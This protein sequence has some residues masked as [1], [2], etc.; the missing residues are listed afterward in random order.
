M[1]F[2]VQQGGSQ[3]QTDDRRYGHLQTGLGKGQG[4]LWKFKDVDFAQPCKSLNANIEVE[5]DVTR[6]CVS[7]AL[8]GNQDVL[9]LFRPTHF[10]R[11][12]RCL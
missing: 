2:L 9:R 8:D 11:L 10:Y 1:S 5:L 7:I 4:R 12:K 6:D 3:G